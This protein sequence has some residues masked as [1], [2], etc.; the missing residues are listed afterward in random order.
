MRPI[1]HYTPDRIKAHIEI[2]F[3]TF[4][5]IR[6]AQE[7]LK[8]AGYPMSVDD[9]R[10]ELIS[11]EASILCDQ[12]TGQHYRMPSHMTVQGRRIY[13]IFGREE[14]LRVRKLDNI[15]ILGQLN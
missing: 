13:E 2:C 1:Y 3:L 10:D 7:R 15:Y 4:T 8:D 9:I 12:S 14:E 11:I 5:L 6:H